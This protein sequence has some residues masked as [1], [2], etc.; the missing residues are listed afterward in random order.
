VVYPLPASRR[1]DRSRWELHPNPIGSGTS[2]HKPVS[3]GGWSRLRRRCPLPY[4]E[5]HPQGRRAGPRFRGTPLF[6]AASCAPP[7]RET[8][9]AAPEVPSID[10]PTLERVCARPAAFRYRSAEE[11]RAGAFSF[12]ARSPAL[13]RPETTVT[14]DRLGFTPLSV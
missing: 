1:R 11:Q 8:R 4:F 7:R 12:T 6:R 3:A 9:S 5:G 13:T 14:R 10:R 2:C